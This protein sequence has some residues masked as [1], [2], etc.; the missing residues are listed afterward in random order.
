MNTPL[1]FRKAIRQVE[2]SNGGQSTHSEVFSL[3]GPPKNMEQALMQAEK[4]LQLPRWPDLSPQTPPPRKPQLDSYLKHLVLQVMSLSVHTSLHTPHHSGYYL[5]GFTGLSRTLD[6]MQPPILP[7]ERAVSS[8]LHL[9]LHQTYGL[10]T[11]LGG[12]LGLLALEAV[13]KWAQTQRGLLKAA[14]ALLPQATAP[15]PALSGGGQNIYHPSNP[16]PTI[17]GAVSIASR[18]PPHRKIQRHHMLDNKARSRETIR[19]F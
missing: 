11:L 14:S 10:S 4:E 3:T 16:V 15:F 1:Y 12:I 13:P 17:P 19:S 6:R 2:A 8:V 7:N 5:I 9:L 18:H